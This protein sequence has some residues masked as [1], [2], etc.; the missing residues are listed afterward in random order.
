MAKIVVV[1][2]EEELRQLIVDELEDAGHQALEAG[3]GIDGLITIMAENPDLI[4]SDV[5]MPRM[6]GFQ[7]KQKLQ[8]LPNHSPTPFLF[9][10]ALAFQ[11]AVERGMSV[12]AD[13]FMTKPV[14]FEDLLSRIE[15]YST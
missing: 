3:D 11:Q 12:G 2:D 7:L 6:D 10:S 5:G 8:E 1:E 14:D 13:E 15:T 9:L 4:I